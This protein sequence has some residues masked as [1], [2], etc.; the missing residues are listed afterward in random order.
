LDKEIQKLISYADGKIISDKDV[1]ILVKAS[2]DSNIF[3]TIDALGANNKKEAIRL[4]HE[5]LKNGDD[6]FYL[7]S[8]FVYQFRN[9]L[10]VADL[11]EKKAN[12][13]E[14]AKMTRMH[15]F[16]IKKSLAQLRNF[17][18]PRLEKIYRKLGAMDLMIKIGKM[19]IR[20]ALDKFVAEL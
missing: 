9:M 4:I 18:F 17:S 11:K 3:K 10:K 2:L 19:D 7:M 6:P 13:Y 1:D 5:H 8:M 12:E 16:V 14:I 15:P 20:L